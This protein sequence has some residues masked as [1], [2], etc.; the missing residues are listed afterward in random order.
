MESIASKFVFG[1]NVLGSM[2]SYMVHGWNKEAYVGDSSQTGSTAPMP[3]F[4]SNQAVIDT[5]TELMK[6]NGNMDKLSDDALVKICRQLEYFYTEEKVVGEKEMLALAKSLV[7]QSVWYHP[8]L[9]EQSA[10]A[11]VSPPDSKVIQS[12]VPKVRFGKTELQISIITCGGMRLQNSWLPDNI[13]MLSP[14]R[15]F[16]LKSPPQKNIKACIQHCLKLGINHFETA[17]MYGTSEYQI[18]AALHELMEEGEIKREDFILQTKLVPADT[19]A[20]MK[21]WDATWS[22]VGE[23]MGYIDL[24]GVHAPADVDEKLQDTIAICKQ[25]QKEGKI[26]HIGFSTHGSSEQIMALLNT[27]YVSG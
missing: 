27:E 7:D 22:N 2:G 4:L 17:R 23:K 24:L 16:V 1:C 5:L 3:T 19:K 14:N 15:D 18:T 9:A 26:R 10:A 8:L 13:P 25:L 12:K 11:T 20:F 21:N 6:E